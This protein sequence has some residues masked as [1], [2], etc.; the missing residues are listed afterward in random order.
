[1]ITIPAALDIVTKHQ[2]K[3][4]VRLIPITNELGIDVYSTQG[5][6]DNLAGKLQRDSNAPSGFA[7]YV[8]ATHPIVRRRFTVAHE[9]AHFILHRNII[10]EAITDDALYRSGLSNSIEA[11]ANRLAAD[12]L[13]PWHLINGAVEA[14]ASTLLDLAHYFDVSQ[15]AMAVRLGVPNES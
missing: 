6:P 9:I 14:G 15:T 3:A 1:M 8:N 12:I 7:I 13:M 5:W 11:A 2:M 4:P 10:D